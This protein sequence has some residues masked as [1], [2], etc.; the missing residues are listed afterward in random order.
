MQI[1]AS[2]YIGREI[3]G[4]TIVELVG[5]GA[6]GAVFV[7]F[8]SSLKRKVAVKI[9]PKTNS[10]MPFFKLR[11]RDEA[12]TVAVLNHPYIAPVFDMGETEDL[13]FLMMQLI[14]GED[15]KGHIKRNQLNPI[16]SRRLLPA[17]FVI[18]LMIKVLDALEYAHREGVIHQDI[19]PGNIIIEERSKRPVLVDF[20]IAHSA[21]A[22]ADTSLYVMGTPLYMS[23]EQILSS[24]PD[25]RS[26]IYS[27]GIV[28]FEALVGKLPLE[29]SKSDQ[30][31]AIKR[32]D[33]DML[34]TC[35]PSQCNPAINF[36]IER[37]ILKAIAADQQNRYQSCAGFKQD[38]EKIRSTVR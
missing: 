29:T 17:G 20:G 31:L 36:E 24:A 9:F 22:E 28:L 4:V 35:R 3:K 15:L 5:R 23:P 13:L 10:A 8:Q 18:D 14:E 27:A 33:P 7:G 37:I 25:R 1:D 26:D 6:M 32:E 11:F 12:E 34:F 2:A 16:P 19:K 30:I 38:L 21:I